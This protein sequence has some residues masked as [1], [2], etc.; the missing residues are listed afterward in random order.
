MGQAKQRK[1][2][3][4]PPRGR[5][6]SSGEADAEEL[7]DVLDGLDALRRVAQHCAEGCSIVKKAIDLGLFVNDLAHESDDEMRAEANAGANELGPR[8]I[9]AIENTRIDAAISVLFGV[10]AGVYNSIEEDNE[11]EA[12]NPAAS[13]ASQM[14]N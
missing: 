1:Q 12:G 8:I 5:A 13:P 10:A 4:L 11:A 9:E 3:G 14:V 7:K 6:G 2:A